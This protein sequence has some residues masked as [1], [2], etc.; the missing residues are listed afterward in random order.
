MRNFLSSEDRIMLIDLIEIAKVSGDYTVAKHNE[1]I[2]RQGYWPESK[3]PVGFFFF[4]YLSPILES[5]NC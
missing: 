3:N 5:E 1:E 4:V 2:L